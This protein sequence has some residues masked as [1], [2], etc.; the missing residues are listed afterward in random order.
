MEWLRPAIA[1]CGVS[2]I[3]RVT[4]LDHVG[5]AVSVAVRPMARS[6]SVS[7]GKGLTSD[8]ADLS[9]A[10]ESI[11][12]W[13]SENAPRGELHGTYAELARAGHPVLDPRTIRPRGAFPTVA[14]LTK[15]SCDWVRAEDLIDGRA[16]L[17]PRWL[18]SI[19]TDDL[20]V[21]HIASTVCSTGLAGGNTLDEATCHAL[22]EVLER[23]AT[24]RLEESTSEEQ[25]LR[26]ID[27]E[28]L[29]G[30]PKAL[31]HQLQIAAIDVELWDQT[32]SSG[33]AS[34]ACS[35]GTTSDVR[36]LARFAGYGAHLAPS[37]AASR[38]ITEA[39]QSRLTIISG[40][41][42]DKPPSTYEAMQRIATSAHPVFT[43]RPRPGRRSFSTLE[44]RT[45]GSFS[46]DLATL[47]ACAQAAGFSSVLRV[48]LTR[49]DLNVPVVF[50]H[51]PLA[52]ISLEG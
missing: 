23:D 50:V 49:S 27:L 2:R 8:L 6:L 32:S 26:K 5:I 51:V 7:Q 39:V 48:D 19:V 37:I 20:H 15:V 36:G 43:A 33:V 35:L 45:T 44:G 12:L 47:L 31:V 40:A 46:T 14:D 9:A 10:M 21:G 3:A 11:E 4:G 38:A 42:D 29:S 16:W 52:K 1:R 30:V 25:E 17:I 24:A 41:R 13:H 34:F 22:A 18:C 28:T